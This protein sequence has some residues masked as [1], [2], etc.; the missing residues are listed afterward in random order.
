M[1]SEPALAAYTKKC[2][3]THTHKNERTQTRSQKAEQNKTNTMV[4][5]G[6]VERVPKSA[7]VRCFWSR[8]RRL[9]KSPK[10]VVVAKRNNRPCKPNR[11]TTTTEPQTHIHTHT[12]AHKKTPDTLVA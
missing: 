4:V 11:T 8:R 9:W 10:T 5:E 6:A 12:P 2:W 7:F 3:H 1:P